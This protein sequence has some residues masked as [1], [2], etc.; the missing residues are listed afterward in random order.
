MKL[1]RVT[2]SP[3]CNTKPTTWD[4]EL[5][6]KHESAGSNAT[7][8]SQDDAQ[9]ASR[10]NAIAAPRLVLML[11]KH[12]GDLKIAGQKHHV[13]QL[14]AHIERIFGK[15]KGDYNDFT[16]CGVHQSRAADGTVTLDQDEYIDALIPI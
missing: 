9:T 7:G 2:R 16:N 6:L 14:I 11:S 3:E 8:T 5:E 15:M 10:G 4:P 12:V 13:E 1:A